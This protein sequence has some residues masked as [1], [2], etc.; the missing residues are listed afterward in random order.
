[1]TKSR[2]NVCTYNSGMFMC[3]QVKR[4]RRQ[5]VRFAVTSAVFLNES[6]VMEAIE[7][8]VR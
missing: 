8:K 4:A 5:I 1:M 6:A 7:K 2:V 3:L